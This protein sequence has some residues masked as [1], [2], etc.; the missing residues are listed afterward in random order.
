[1]AVFF[2]STTVMVAEPL[3]YTDRTCCVCGIQLTS[4]NPMAVFRPA[5]RLAWSPPIRPSQA[6]LHVISGIDAV[7][8]IERM[9][10][11]PTAR[12]PAL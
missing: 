8:A 11:H 12:L 3:R 10:T 9:A 4:V 1:M 5:K 7:Q 6:S 2:T